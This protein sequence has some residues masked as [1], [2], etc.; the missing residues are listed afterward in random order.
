MKAHS[1]FTEEEATVFFA[2]LFNGKHHIPGTGLKPFE[3]GWCVNVYQSD[4]S[5]FDFSL[6]TGFVFL[7]HDYCMRAGIY[8]SGPG[9]VKIAVWKREGRTGDIY[10]RHPTVEQALADW[11]EK[12][13]YF[14]SNLI[15]WIL[16][17]FT[18]EVNHGI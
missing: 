2:R 9:L 18:S 8:P 10:N 11:R 4:L 13:F 16:S 1:K 7:A 5:T 15:G 14:T 12:S 17:R 3:G 6:L